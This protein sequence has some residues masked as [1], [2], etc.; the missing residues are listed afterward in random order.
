MIR[1][2][3]VITFALLQYMRHCQIKQQ[4][5]AYL[6]RGLRVVASWPRYSKLKTTTKMNVKLRWVEEQHR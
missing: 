2:F 3:S 6:E 1:A 5:G 4:Q